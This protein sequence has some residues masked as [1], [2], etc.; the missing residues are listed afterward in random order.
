M[1]KR[2]LLQENLI[3][4]LQKPSLLAKKNWRV[5][6]R[7]KRRENVKKKNF[8]NSKRKKRNARSVSLK[9]K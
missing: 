6:K 5:N 9:R 3:L 7:R 8:Y 4:R 1:K 2:K